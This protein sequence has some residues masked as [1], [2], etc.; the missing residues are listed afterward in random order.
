MMAPFYEKMLLV[1]QDAPTITMSTEIYWE[2]DDMI[3]EVIERQGNYEHINSQIRDAIIVGCKVLEEYTAKMDSETIIPY[4]AS[5]LDP[6]VK[7]E[8]LK[9]HLKD[10]ADAVIDNL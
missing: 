1:S 4:A 8:W 7:T 6:R 3:D 5:V 9:N 2:I 10:N